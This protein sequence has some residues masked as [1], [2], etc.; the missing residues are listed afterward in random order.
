MQTDVAATA[1]RE[2]ES[3][4][5]QFSATTKD[6]GMGSMHVRV[7]STHPNPADNARHLSDTLTYYVSDYCKKVLTGARLLLSFFPP[8]SGNGGRAAGNATGITL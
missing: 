2:R 7:L 3:G 1:E 8:K 4:N 5:R 6:H